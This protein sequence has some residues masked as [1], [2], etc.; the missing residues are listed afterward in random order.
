MSKLIY[1]LTIAPLMRSLKNLDAI[2]SKAEA[3]VGADNNIVE[4]TNIL[5]HNG[6]VIDKHDYLGDI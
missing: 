2:V 6:V 5:R 1:D 3:Y 4:G